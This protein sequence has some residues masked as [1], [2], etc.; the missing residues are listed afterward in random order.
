MMATREFFMMAKTD[1]ASVLSCPGERV[2]VVSVGFL[3]GEDVDASSDKAI[4]SSK[5]SLFEKFPVCVPVGQ[6]EPRGYWRAI[7]LLKGR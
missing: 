4:A 6:L 2:I 3:A 1:S 5:F 7:C